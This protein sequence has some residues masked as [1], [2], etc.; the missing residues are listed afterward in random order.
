ML[1]DSSGKSLV[2]P[3]GL[4]V[5]GANL[6]DFSRSQFS[7]VTEV[8]LKVGVQITQRL[9]TNFG[10]QF[11]YW[12]NVV[13]PGEQIDRNIDPRQVPS[14]LA[15]IPGFVGTQPQ[16]LFASTDFWLQGLTL[17]LTFEF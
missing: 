15:F 7:V 12:D 10:Y 17:G 11:L 14:N 13:R 4:Y 1:T 5:V 3:G 6:G 9:R 2:A 16:L 8:G